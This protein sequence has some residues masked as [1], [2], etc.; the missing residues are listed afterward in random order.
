MQNQAEHKTS[1]HTINYFYLLMSQ[2][3]QF[4]NTEFYSG[5]DFLLQQE[6]YINIMSMSLKCKIITS[7]VH[8]DT[9]SDFT[10]SSLVCSSA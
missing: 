4:N 7:T 2:T 6:C 3:K 5:F 10:C 1:I 8:L 9:Q